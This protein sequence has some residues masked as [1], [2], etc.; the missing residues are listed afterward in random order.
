MHDSILSY[1]FCPNCTQDSFL[2]NKFHWENDEIFDGVLLCSNCGLWYKIENGILD[3]LPIHLRR[4]D[5]YRQF[6]FLHELEFESSNLV[7]EDS[8]KL[9]QITF[10]EKQFESYEETVVNSPFYRALNFLTFEK[11]LNLNYPSLLS[12]ILEIGCG[13]GRQTLI[14]AN[15][16]LHV[17]ATDISEEMIK[18]AQQKTNDVGLSNYV[19]YIVLDAENLPFKNDLFGACVCCSTLHHLK[20]P[21]K[22]ILD[23]SKKLKT[24]GLFYT[25]DPHDS[26]I[27]FLFNFLMKLWKLYD[28]KDSG[29]PLMNRKDLVRWLN[30]AKIESKIKY[31]TYLPPHLFLPLSDKAAINL[32]KNSDIVFNSIPKFYVFAGIIISEGVKRA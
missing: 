29:N 6:A 2:L 14:M 20:H 3:L 9:E 12:P 1:I 18:L 16:K 10:F 11:W 19:D 23:S 21:E 32:L 17:I 25:I 26:Y 28:E 30:K 27:R 15:K 13:T 7:L 31:S 24:F 4:I 8:Q 5:L 22:I